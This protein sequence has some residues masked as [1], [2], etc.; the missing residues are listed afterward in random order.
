MIPHNIMTLFSFGNDNVIGQH[1]G[2]EFE[3]ILTKIFLFSLYFNP[4]KT[5]N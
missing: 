5:L 3:K 4:V 1:G 2:L